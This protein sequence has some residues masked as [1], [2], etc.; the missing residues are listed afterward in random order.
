MCKECDGSGRLEKKQCIE[1]DGIGSLDLCTD[2]SDYNVTCK[3][4]DGIGGNIVKEG[5]DCY[6]CHGG[7]KWYGKN[8]T[9]DI[10]GVNIDPRFYSKI[11]NLDD[12][13]IAAGEDRLYFQSGQAKGMIMAVRVKP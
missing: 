10:L 8:K 2:F 4:C 7:G 1:C 12:L 3:T 6:Q 9:M 5:F 11:I 13:I